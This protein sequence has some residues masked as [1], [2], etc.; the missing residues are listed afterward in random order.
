MSTLIVIRWFWWILTGLSL[1]MALC[2]I[3]DRSSAVMAGGILGTAWF[4]GC[5]L[6]PDRLWL[7]K[8]RRW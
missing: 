1:G 2:G 7:K 8:Q 4:T 5:A 3:Y 6:S